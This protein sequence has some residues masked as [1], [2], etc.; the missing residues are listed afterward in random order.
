MLLAVLRVVRLYLA[1][2]RLAL[3]VSSFK[4]AW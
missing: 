2:N 3:L 4:A 1:P